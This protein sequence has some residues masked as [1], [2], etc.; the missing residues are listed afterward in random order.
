MISQAIKRH[1]ENLILNVYDQVSCSNLTGKYLSSPPSPTPLLCFCIFPLNAESKRQHTI[2]QSIL[3]ERAYC[4]NFYKNGIWL[5]FMFYEPPF[6]INLLEFIVSFFH[7][8]YSV[9]DMSSFE[10]GCFLRNMK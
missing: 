2:I 1:R 3:F 7:P 8:V 9:L 6:N 5:C 10:L 4:L